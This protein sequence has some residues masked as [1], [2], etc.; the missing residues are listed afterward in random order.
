MCL[1]A[2]VLIISGEIIRILWDA[3][4]LSSVS[5]TP[6][7]I[8]T[9]QEWKDS[10]SKISYDSL[11]RYAEEYRGKRVYF[12]GKVIQVIESRGG[13]QLRVNVTEGEY[14]FWDDTVFLRYDDA[15]VRILEDD[16]VAFVGR[17]NGTITYE[18]VLGA[19]ITIPD[20]TVLDLVIGGE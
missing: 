10:A 12:R 9:W 17:M 2:I 18:S 14:G 7:P 11:F 5:P 8:L 19:E 20:I 4:V 1:I 6:A 3:G 13:F 16:I 15:P